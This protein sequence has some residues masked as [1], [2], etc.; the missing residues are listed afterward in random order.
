MRTLAALAILTA[1]L[2]LAGLAIG[3]VPLPPAALFDIL[4]GSGRA[5]PGLAMILHD[6]RLPRVALAL[7]AGAALALAGAI[8]QAV[9]RNPLAEPGVLGIN[10]GAALAVMIGLVGMRGLPPG[11][12]PLAGFAGSLAMAG[13]VY[14]LAWRRGVTA[15]RLILVGIGLG[16]L[17]SALTT[18]LTAFGE[19]AR[20][21]TA[22]IWLA[23]SLHHADWPAVRLL[24]L[25]LVLPGACAM[26]AARQLDLIRLGDSFARARGQ[27][28]TRL[29]ALMIL[30]CAAISG[31]AVAATGLIGF[32]GLIAP[33]LARRLVGPLHRLAL[34]ASALVGALMVTAAD[35][36][37]RTIIA[38][39][40]LPAGIV[41]A[42]IGAP[43]FGALLW[44]HRLAPA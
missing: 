22:L 37:G 11:I 5:D 39:V 10:A 7:L 33:H 6:L 40:Q 8:S 20:V 14:L 19:L 9:M 43:V 28:V 3:E 32:V 24:G 36:L 34:P 12:A 4:S 27:H 31:A 29:R 23:G 2:A 18:V 41:T 35:L 16:A 26:M 1:A 30:A 25:W 42:L 17:A 15:L 38:P 21:Q 44:R 13:A